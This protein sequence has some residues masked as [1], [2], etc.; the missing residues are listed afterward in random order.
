MKEI[1]RLMIVDDN[2]NVSADL[3]TLLSLMENVEVIGEA[4]DNDSAVAQSLD[5]YPDII[6]MDLEMK[7]KYQLGKNE[8][9][10]EIEGYLTIKILKK[11]QPNLT[12]IVLTDHDYKETELAAFEAGA[13][14]FLIKGKD[15][16]KLLE[17]IRS[18]KR[19]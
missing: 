10:N 18:Y 3:K 17:M 19:K 15:T 16:K 12:I 7:R 9:E 6:V 8:I 5:L 11:N 1:T 14:A 2:A 4:T 13:N